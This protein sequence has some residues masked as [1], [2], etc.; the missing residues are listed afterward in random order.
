MRNQ[1]AF[2][3][4][5]AAFGIDRRERR[6]QVVADMQ[7]VSRFSAMPC[8]RMI[9]LQ[10]RRHVTGG[11]AGHPSPDEHV[12]AFGQQRADLAGGNLDAEFQQLLVQQRLVTWL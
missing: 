11:R 2:Q 5:D 4:V 10:V 9:G 1:Q 3:K 6:E 8:R 12:M 7:R